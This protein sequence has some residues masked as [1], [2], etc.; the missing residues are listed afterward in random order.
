[1]SVAILAALV[2]LAVLPV[3]TWDRVPSVCPW[4]NLFGVRCAGCGG[5]HAVAALL[6]GEVA[7]ALRYNAFALFVATVVTAAAIRDVMRL[8][9]VYQRA[10]PTKRT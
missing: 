1:V 5:I 9:V 10:F 7:M 6:H 3:D 4:R 2:L 8:P